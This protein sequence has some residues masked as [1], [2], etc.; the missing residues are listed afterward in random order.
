MPFGSPIGSIDAEQARQHHL[1]MDPI[2]DFV[3][4]YLAALADIRQRQ[5]ERQRRYRQRRKA[6]ADQ[7]SGTLVP[8]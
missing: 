4:R 6:A 7:V 5:R 3:R 8:D 2:Q 1:G